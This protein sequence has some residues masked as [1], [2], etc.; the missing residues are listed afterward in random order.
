M[1]L[2]VTSH[3]LTNRIPEAVNRLNELLSS[4]E[5]VPLFK[6]SP[7]LRPNGLFDQSKKT[8]ETLGC[9]CATAACLGLLLKK[10]QVLKAMRVLHTLTLTY[11]RLSASHFPCEALAE[12]CLLP[13]G[14][15][16]AARVQQARAGMTERGLWALVPAHIQDD[17]VNALTRV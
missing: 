13:Q 8:V 2:S 7:A 16:L 12:M 1:F 9:F 5:A 3:T 11:Y 15:Q 4:M 17:E 14:Q 6:R 10:S